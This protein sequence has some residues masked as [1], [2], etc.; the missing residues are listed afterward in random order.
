[1]FNIG[2]TKD[3]FK[4]AAWTFVQAF[5]VVF[6]AGLN[7]LLD[8]FKAGG[9]DA[10]QAAGVALVVAAAAAGISALKGLLLADTSPLK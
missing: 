9:L 1:M 8:A 6:A 7:D 3:D 2:F 10:A 5:V 4:R